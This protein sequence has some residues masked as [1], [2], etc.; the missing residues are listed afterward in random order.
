M[1]FKK[2]IEKSIDLHVHIGPEI[3]PRKFDL[4]K[5]INYEK[6]KI[7]GLG[8]KNHFFPTIA[9][10]KVD[11]I[12]NNPLIIH[13]V[14][15]NNYL[16]GFNP[17]A[18]KASAELS[19]NRIIVWFPTLNAKRFLL[20]QKH[21]IPSEWI[22]Q[23]K[24]RKIALCPSGIIKGLTVFNQ[25]DRQISTEVLEVLQAVKKYDAILATG[26]IS[27]Q[28][29]SELVKM[30]KQKFKIKRVIIT[31]PIYQRINMPL[32][33]QKKLAIMGAFIEHSYS[34]NTIDKILISKIAKQIK[35]VGSENCILT[36]DVG[37]KFNPS[38]SEALNIFANLLFKNGITQNEIEKMLIHN[39][40]KLVM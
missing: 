26:H 30:A 15:L 34:M 40:K 31:H 8:I 39:P 22:N 12:K 9:A 7:Y 6:N 3:I 25:N 13:S 35:Y 32:N 37:Q 16:G 33:I 1:N 36:S 28:E 18:I 20:N 5:I 14:T 11:L 17:E 29:S 4:E 21:E 24:G 38:P 27:W 10:K 19:D 2:I 23:K